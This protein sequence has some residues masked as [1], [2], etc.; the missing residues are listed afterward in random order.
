MLIGLRAHLT[1]TTVIFILRHGSRRVGTP[2]TCK[3]LTAVK[4]ATASLQ[5]IL[6][7][8]CRSHPLPNSRVY[9]WRIADIRHLVLPIL[10]APPPSSTYPHGGSL[11]PRHLVFHFPHVPSSSGTPTYA[12]HLRVLPPPHLRRT[13]ALRSAVYIYHSSATTTFGSSTTP[14]TSIPF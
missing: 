1:A 12:V 2:A 5:L 11:P 9:T 10:A 7:Y 6:L 14:Y 8:H 3:N 13:G 4:A